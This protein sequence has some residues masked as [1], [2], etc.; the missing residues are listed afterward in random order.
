MVIDTGTTPR[1]VMAK[2]KLYQSTQKLF[3][4]NVI[5]FAERYHDLIRKYANDFHSND[6]VNYYINYYDPYIIKTP[7]SQPK[8]IFSCLVQGMPEFYPVYRQ[9]TYIQMA[10]KYK[11]MVFG[12]SVCDYIKNTASERAYPY[13]T[14]VLNNGE[15]VFWDLRS[16]EIFRPLPE[17]N[18]HLKRMRPDGLI[19]FTFPHAVYEQIQQL[20][21]LTV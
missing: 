4:N 12:K 16:D 9:D 1:V 11:E 19:T 7:S 8:I 5:T 10:R 2:L 6:E 21:Q 15:L 3:G 13:T 17:L 14:H 18:L 20:Y